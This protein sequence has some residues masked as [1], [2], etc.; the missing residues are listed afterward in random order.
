[1]DTALLNCSRNNMRQLHFEPLPNFSYPYSWPP[2]LFW[3]LRSHSRFRALVLKDLAASCS[4]P[5]AT[6]PVPAAFPQ[7]LHKP[8]ALRREHPIRKARGQ[9]PWWQRRPIGVWASR[10]GLGRLR[11]HILGSRLQDTTVPGCL[12]QSLRFQSLDRQS[13][14]PWW[15]KTIKSDKTKISGLSIRP[16]ALKNWRVRSVSH[17]S[18]WWSDITALLTEHELKWWPE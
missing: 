3:T 6:P 18:S 13:Y 16:M 17:C 14:W 8:H 2:E 9:L 10:R 4:V 15:E 11:G 5:S 7:C 12:H 1:M